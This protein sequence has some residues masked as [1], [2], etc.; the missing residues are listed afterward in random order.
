[1]P[2]PMLRSGENTVVFTDQQVAIITLNLVKLDLLMLS[3][4]DSGRLIWSGNVIS[5][6]RLNTLRTKHFSGLELKPGSSIVGARYWG[7]LWRF[8]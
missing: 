4:R 8:F 6:L 5:E 3:Y 7:H 2:V 1:M